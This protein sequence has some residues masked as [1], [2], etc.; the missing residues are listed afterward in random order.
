MRRSRKIQAP[1]GLGIKCFGT[2]AVHRL[3]LLESVGEPALP[4]LQTPSQSPLGAGQHAGQ[5]ADQ[6]PQLG[7]HYGLGLTPRPIIA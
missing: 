4:Y 1:V 7:Q 6:R 3:H 5:Q 2:L